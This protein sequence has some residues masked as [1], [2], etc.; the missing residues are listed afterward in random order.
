MQHSLQGY[1]GDV[2]QFDGDCVASVEALNHDDTVRCIMRLYK[3]KNDFVCQ[4]I[5]EPTT[6]DACYRLER[7]TETI[8]IYQF[9]GTEPLA[10]Y[11][12][13]SAGIEVPG[14]RKTT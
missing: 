2:L 11:L 14:L 5:D 13:G 12:Y 3:T 1:Q 9:F 7:C 10:N 6:K 4:R 8:E